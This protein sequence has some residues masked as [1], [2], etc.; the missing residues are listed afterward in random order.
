MRG[1]GAA[2]RALPGGV[3][4][5]MNYVYLLKSKKDGNG[6]IGSTIDL[7]QRVEQHNSGKV[8]STKFRRPLELTGYQQFEY[9]RKY[10]KSHNALKRVIKSGEFKIISGM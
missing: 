3:E 5:N 8:K 10:E 1:W 4:F 7:S 2:Q 6:Y 9:E